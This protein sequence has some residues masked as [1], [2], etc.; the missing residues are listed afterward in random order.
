MVDFEKKYPVYIAI[1][2]E[3]RVTR[4]KN[5]ADPKIKG[6]SSSPPFTYA[7]LVLQQVAEPLDVAGQIAFRHQ[8]GAQRVALRQN[9]HNLCFR[10]IGIIFQPVELRL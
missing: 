9:G 3:S 10:S 5:K 2:A 8:G 6:Q 4:I 7:L 1:I